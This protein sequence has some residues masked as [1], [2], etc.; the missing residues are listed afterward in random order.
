MRGKLTYK[1]F[2]L[3]VIAIIG[4]KE[5]FEPNLPSVPQGYL[6]VE[7]FI[8]VQ[9][10]TQIKLSRSV[11]IDQKKILKPELNAQIKI[12]G[13]N[14]TSVTLSNLPNGVYVSNTLSLDASRKYRLRIK[15]TNAKEY[16]SDFSEV[17]IT[18]PLDSINWK[19]ETG[20]VRIYVNTHDAQNKTTYYRWDYDETWEIQ[21]AYPALYRLERVVL[22]TGERIIRET[23]AND[24]QIFYCWK[25]DTLKNIILGSSAKLDED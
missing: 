6:V 19:Q 24:P 5:P 21:S 16:L 17:K 15:T 4:C 2:A 23:N 25:Y 1:I 11:P 20:G 8:N 18:P 22:N 14:N 12:E 3:L 7:G 10:R 13:D 9:G